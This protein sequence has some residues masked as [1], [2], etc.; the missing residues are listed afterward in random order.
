MSTDQLR[1][2]KSA[3]D[4]V[5]FRLAFIGVSV[6]RKPNLFG[7]PVGKA[8][9]CASYAGISISRFDIG[10][11]AEE[12]QGSPARCGPGRVRAGSVRYVHNAPPDRNSWPPSAV[13]DVDTCIGVRPRMAT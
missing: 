8:A 12:D 1:S 4:E 9:G 5:P 2:G 13:W 6:R 11:S 7:N 10:S 3:L